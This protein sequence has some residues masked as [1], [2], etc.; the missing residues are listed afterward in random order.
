MET[1]STY[2]TDV[3]KLNIEDLKKAADFI[4]KKEQKQEKEARISWFTKMMNKFGWHR[5]Y[6]VIIIDKEKIC[7]IYYPF[8]V[9]NLKEE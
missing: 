2:T 3:A 7:N 5:K 9:K 4:I 6:E 1:D 8:V